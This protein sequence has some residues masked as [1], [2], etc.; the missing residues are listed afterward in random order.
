MIRPWKDI[1]AYY[2]EL[3]VNGLPYQAMVR[4]VEQIEASRYAGGVHGETSMHDLCVTVGKW[5]LP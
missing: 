4:L 2:R 1:G 5:Q 3:V